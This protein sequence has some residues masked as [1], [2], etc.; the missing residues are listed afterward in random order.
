M[1]VCINCG[2]DLGDYMPD[3]YGHTCPEC[4]ASIE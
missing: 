1:E 2:E 3:K 4:G